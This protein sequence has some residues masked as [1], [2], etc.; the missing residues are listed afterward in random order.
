MAED[1]TIEFLAKIPLFGDLKRRQLDLLARLVGEKTYQPGEAIVRQGQGG[2]GLF[3]I[4]AGKADV[5]RQTVDGT[6]TVVNTLGPG[7][8]FGELALLDDGQRTASVV[9]V[10]PT[11]CMSMTRWDF[12]PLLK[13]DADM[14]ILILQEIVQRFRRALDTF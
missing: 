7:D 8:F 6:E 5:L 1:K 13:D 12:M 2:V 4:E 3:I 10:E 9:A 11:T 14:A